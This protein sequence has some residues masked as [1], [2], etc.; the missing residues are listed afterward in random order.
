VTIGPLI[1][2]RAVEKADELVRDAVAHGATLRVAG[3]KLERAGTFYAATVL[4]DVAPG[5]P[6]PA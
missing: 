3:E 6:D 5:Q 2:E 4:S 1:D